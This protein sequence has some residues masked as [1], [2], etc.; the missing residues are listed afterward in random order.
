M[1][2][3]ESALLR[4]AAALPARLARPAVASILSII[5]KRGLSDVIPRGRMTRAEAIHRKRMVTAK[6]FEDSILRVLKYAKHETLRNL[7]RHS[8]ATIASAAEKKEPPK[9]TIVFDPAEFERDLLAALE[10]DHADALQIAGQ[11]L[12]DEIGK[13]DPFKMPARKTLDFI[14]K[15]QNLLS[16]VS[17]EIHA[18][19]EEALAAGI[20]AREPLRELSKRISNKFEEIYKGRGRVVADTETAA[21]YSYARNQAMKEAGIER[22]KW[23]HSPLAKTPRPEHVAMHG[24]IVPINEV[25][26]VGNPPLMYP[27]DPN[28]SPEDVINCHCMAIPVE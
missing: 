19:I 22:K 3:I 26:P 13:E 12:F 21:A 14:R 6:M 15:R 11:E 20:Q 28:G 2:P 5:C 25:F 8:R 16:G 4:R 24:K 17:D 10:S 18:Q 9:V 1:R 27:H 23:L 7:E